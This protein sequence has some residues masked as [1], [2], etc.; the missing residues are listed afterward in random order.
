MSLPFAIQAADE[1]HSLERLPPGPEEPDL[2][3][4]LPAEWC[5]AKMRALELVRQRQEVG[6]EVGGSG[7]VEPESLLAFAIERPRPLSQLRRNVTAAT[8]ELEIDEGQEKSIR[9]VLERVGRQLERVVEDDLGARRG[10][11]VRRIEANT[12]TPIL[13]VGARIVV[14]H[15]KLGVAMSLDLEPANQGTDKTSSKVVELLPASKPVLWLLLRQSVPCHQAADHGKLHGRPGSSHPRY[16]IAAPPGAPE[17]GPPLTQQ[18]HSPPSH[19]TLPFTGRVAL[20]TG[21]G[22]GIGRA[23]ATELAVAGCAVALM[24]RREE[25]LEKAAS[26]LEAA[27]A[28]S[29]VVAGDVADAESARQVVATVIEELGALH[30]LV[31][32]AGIARGGAIEE[33][34]DGD[35]DL[36]VDIDLKGPMHMIRAAL[37]YLRR[38]REDGGASILN[39]SSSVTFS[40]VANYS[41]YSAAKAGV[42]MLTRCLAVELAEDRIR[43][44]AI[45]PGVVRTPIFETMMSPEDAH[46]MLD[47]MGEI[48]PLGRIGDPRDI[49]TLALFLVSEPAA[50]TTGAVIPLDGGLS[51]T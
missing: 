1:L 17:R 35:L 13:S 47:E 12:R 10:D 50:W 31:N 16:N 37:P 34:A 32:N 41:I 11:I 19:N 7:D 36:V 28:R 22:S 43:V 4:E 38:H 26:E 2:L 39:I 42:D 6:A 21:A 33:L 49:A 25:R 15:R 48:V 8:V 45:C 23:I 24:G 9:G 46:K 14:R 20:V 18:D 3:A 40:P 44:N 30:I 27:G 51:L 5:A 29:L